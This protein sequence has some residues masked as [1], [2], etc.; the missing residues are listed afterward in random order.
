MKDATGLVHQEGKI[1]SACAVNGGTW[2]FVAYTDRT[3]PELSNLRLAGRS[4]ETSRYRACCAD[5]CRRGARARQGL[6]LTALI[7][8]PASIC[9]ARPHWTS[10]GARIFRIGLDAF[11]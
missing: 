8:L 5:E 10:T 7:Q 4:P 2:W 3:P 1:G 9:W 6:G 11:N